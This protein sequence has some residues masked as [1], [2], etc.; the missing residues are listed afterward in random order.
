[1]SGKQQERGEAN[2]F[3]KHMGVVYVDYAGALICEAFVKP[4]SYTH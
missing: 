4:I 2:I 1:M 3:L